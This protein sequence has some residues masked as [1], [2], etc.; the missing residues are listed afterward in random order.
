MLQRLVNELTSVAFSFT[1]FFIQL[2][3]TTSVGPIIVLRKN[4]DLCS[5]KNMS[6][7]L[8]ITLIANGIPIACPVKETFTHCYGGQKVF[9]LSL[10]SQKMLL[11]F[12]FSRQAHFQMKFD[13]D[14]GSTCFEGDIEVLKST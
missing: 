9:K 8:H 6:E 5:P 4:V 12:S 1:I 11:M 13:H 7:I 10:K 14:V 3:L 2:V